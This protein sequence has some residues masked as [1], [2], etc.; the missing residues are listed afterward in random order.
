MVDFTIREF[1]RIDYFVNSAGV[2]TQ[3]P[4]SC[5]NFMPLHDA[6]TSLTDLHLLG[7]GNIPRTN[8]R[9]RY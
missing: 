7:W 8:I 1:G 3:R 4:Y 5:E 2:S 6:W 9:Y